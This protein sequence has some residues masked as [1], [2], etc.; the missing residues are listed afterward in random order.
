MASSKVVT[1]MVAALLGFGVGPAAAQTTAVAARTATVYVPGLL[2]GPGSFGPVG[3]RRLCDLRVVGL[4][5]WRVRYIERAIEPTEPQKAALA[6]LQAASSHA[7]GALAAA[8]PT[9]RPSTSVEEL[10]MMDK[11]LAALTQAFG[12]IKPV[13]EAFYA[14]LDSRQKAQLD[15]LGPQRRGWRW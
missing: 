4:V 3:F 1:F 12:S 15:G 13:Y 7:R 14:M 9:S 10:A 6:A 8:C 11:R 2:T 5:E